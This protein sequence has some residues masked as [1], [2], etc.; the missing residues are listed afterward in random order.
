MDPRPQQA[1]GGGLD[2]MTP[3]SFFHPKLLCD[4]CDAV[5]KYFISNFDDNIK[6]VTIGG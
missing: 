6:T 4:F 2:Y 3:R 5:K 1:L